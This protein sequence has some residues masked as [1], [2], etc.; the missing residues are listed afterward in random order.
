MTDEEIQGYVDAKGD[1]IQLYGFTSTTLN[2]DIA[3]KFAWENKDTN[4][5]KKKVVFNIKWNM[6]GSH[7]YLDAGAFDYEEEILLMD[8]VTLQVVEVQDIQENG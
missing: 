4:P 8:G 3:M 6:P 2:K 1:K 5:P 7:Y